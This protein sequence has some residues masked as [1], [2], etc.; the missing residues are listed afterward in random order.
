MC[1]KN[2]LGMVDIDLIVMKNINNIHQSHWMNRCIEFIHNQCTTIQD[3]INHK[4][5]LVDKANRSIRFVCISLNCNFLVLKN[6]TQRNIVT[7]CCLPISQ[8]IGA[9]TKCLCGISQRSFNINGVLLWICEL[10]HY[11]YRI[12]TINYHEFLVKQ[13]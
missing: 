3:C 1:I 7:I 2:K 13:F 6:R 8:S 11:L 5:E 12:C 4:W 9:Y 10:P